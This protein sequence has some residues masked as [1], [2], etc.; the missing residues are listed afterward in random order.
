MAGGFA[1]G[2]LAQA[3]RQGP[4]TE[5]ALE[6]ERGRTVLAARGER[7]AETDPPGAAPGLVLERLA[8]GSDGGIMSAA[9]LF[10]GGDEGEVFGT[11]GGWRG[12]RADWR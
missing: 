2:I 3:L 12:G 7:D 4:V 5:C 8:I 11:L 1:P 10:E 6:G 9:T